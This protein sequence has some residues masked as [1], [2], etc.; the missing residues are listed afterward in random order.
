MFDGKGLIFHIYIFNQGNVGVKVNF[1]DFDYSV[2][3]GVKK[4]ILIV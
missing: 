4:N 2:V 1:C 3:V